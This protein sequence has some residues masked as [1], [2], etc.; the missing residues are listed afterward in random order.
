MRVHREELLTT[1][2]AAKRGYAAVPERAGAPRRREALGP[3]KKAGEGA[4]MTS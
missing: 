1:A 4:L 3:D 2:R